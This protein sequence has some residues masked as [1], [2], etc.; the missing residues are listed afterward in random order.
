[1]Q[2][3]K[4]SSKRKN[5][6]SVIFKTG[7]FDNAESVVIISN[8]SKTVPNSLTLQLMMTAESMSKR[9]VLRITV[10]LLFL[11]ELVDFTFFTL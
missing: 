3:D 7:R 1:M 9:R 10:S 8:A 5:K 6:A 2:W 11:L 4:N